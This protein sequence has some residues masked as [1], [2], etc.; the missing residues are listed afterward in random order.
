MA[1]KVFISYPQ[2]ADQ[3]LALRLQ[4]L[5]GTR[6]GLQ[7]YVPPASTRGRASLPQT[8]D[9]RELHKADLVLALV[10]RGISPTMQNELEVARRSQKPVVPVVSGAAD[11]TG[12]QPG[13][14]VFYVDP[15]NT[16]Q[17]EQEIVDYL[18]QAHL[19]KA[20]VEAAVGLVLLAAGMLI[21][22]NK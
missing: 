6:P 1:P 5:A 22:A 11:I 10:S 2:R 16:R 14:P 13:Q 3:V 17:A 19:G 7:V 15:L 20:N 8:A 9:I 21:L 18:E 12:L 4:T